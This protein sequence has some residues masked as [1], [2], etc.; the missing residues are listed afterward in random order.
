MAN[1]LKLTPIVKTSTN[2]RFFEQ[3]VIPGYIMDTRYVMDTIEESQL[4]PIAPGDPFYREPMEY[5]VKVPE[6]CWRYRGWVLYS[7]GWASRYDSLDMYYRMY[8]AKPNPKIPRGF[9]EQGLYV[10]CPGGS[11]KIFWGELMD[12]GIRDGQFRIPVDYAAFHDNKEY[13]EKIMRQIE[14]EQLQRLMALVDQEV[15]I[16]A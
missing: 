3:P 14:A 2:A 11:G 13:M 16:P 1:K 5:V 4:I 10:S 9:D 7:S 6:G 12:T 8:A 15:D